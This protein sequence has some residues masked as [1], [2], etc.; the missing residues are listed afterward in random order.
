MPDHIAWGLNM[1]PKVDKPLIKMTFIF[2][3]RRYKNFNS[4][5]YLMKDNLKIGSERDFSAN[6]FARSPEIDI[7]NVKI[8]FC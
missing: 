1:V 5:P 7:S 3:A 2:G 8:D 4:A 6:V